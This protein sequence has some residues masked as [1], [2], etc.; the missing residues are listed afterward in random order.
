MYSRNYSS[1]CSLTTG[2]ANARSRTGRASSI[3][4]PRST[5]LSLSSA[6][7]LNSLSSV[8][9]SSLSPALYSVC[10]SHLRKCAAHSHWWLRSYSRCRTP[11][12]VPNSGWCLTSILLSNIRL[13]EPCT[14][15]SMINPW[16]LPFLP[17]MRHDSAALRTRKPCPFT[18][19][20]PVFRPGLEGAP[21]R[22]LL[23]DD[24]PDD[25]CKTK[26]RIALRVSVRHINLMLLQ[27]FQD[28]VLHHL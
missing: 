7:A 26:P 5:T 14:K 24:A 21:A 8:S 25:P 18:S 11:L 4:V 23:A 17:F 9:K 20:A 6:R 12:P 16:F 3:A 13:Y 1:S 2:R 10:V 22:F 15:P 27:C 28:T 19:S